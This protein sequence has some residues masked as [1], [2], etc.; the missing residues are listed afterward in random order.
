MCP[1]SRRLANSHALALF[2]TVYHDPFA[3]PALFHLPPSSSLSPFSLG[4]L[5]LGGASALDEPFLSLE[6]RTAFAPH[7]LSAAGAAT[8]LGPLRSVVGALRVVAQRSV[9]RGAASGAGAG[10]GA[11]VRVV[12]V[13]S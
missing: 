10:G 7:P 8:G 9:P 2:Q 11:V 5:G 6:T 12:R 1:S 4:S 13:P 3:P